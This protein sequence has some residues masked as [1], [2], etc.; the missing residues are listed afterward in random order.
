MVTGVG[1]LSRNN[2]NSNCSWALQCKC[3]SRTGFARG[4]STAPGFQGTFGCSQAARLLWALGNAKNIRIFFKLRSLNYL[5]DLILN[6]S[7]PFSP[8]NGNNWARL[9]WLP[10]RHQGSSSSVWTDSTLWAATTLASLAKELFLE[11]WFF[12]LPP[13]APGGCSSISQQTQAGLC[14]PSPIPMTRIS[15]WGCSRFYQCLKCFL[16]RALWLTE[17]EFPRWKLL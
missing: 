5:H 11:S 13:A 14:S 15:A 16:A 10:T 17:K 7:P 8:W 6:F 9:S 12:S 1:E 2:Y 4:S 3:R